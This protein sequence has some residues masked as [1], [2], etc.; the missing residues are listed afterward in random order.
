MSETQNF[1]DVIASLAV[2]HYSRSNKSRKQARSIK[3]IVIKD[4]AIEVNEVKEVKKVKK[5]KKVQITQ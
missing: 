2:G 3:D 1:L 4:I 5:V